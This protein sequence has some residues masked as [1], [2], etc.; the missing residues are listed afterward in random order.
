MSR[1]VAR[2]SRTTKDTKSHEDN[3]TETKASWSFVVKAV[4]LGVH[5]N[6]KS[7]I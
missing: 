5:Q 2:E 6:L 7:A 3:H 4:Q 1:I